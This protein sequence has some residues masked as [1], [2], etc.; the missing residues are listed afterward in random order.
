MKLKGSGI[1]FVIVLIVMA[2]V[3]FLTAKSW[4]AAAPTLAT[5]PGAESAGPVSDHGQ[6]EAVVALRATPLGFQNLD[7]MQ[8][9]TDQHVNQVQEIMSQAE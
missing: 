3:L 6:T 1:G 4:N 7:E 5:L 8:Q 2:I 9:S